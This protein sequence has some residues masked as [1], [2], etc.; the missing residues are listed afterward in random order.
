M[1]T[2]R[3]IKAKN[4]RVPNPS[5]DPKAARGCRIVAVALM[6]LYTLGIL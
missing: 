6:A 4:L 5:Y 1:S 3:T 2:G